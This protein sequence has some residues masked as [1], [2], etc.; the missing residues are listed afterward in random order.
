MMIGAMKTRTLRDGRCRTT[1]VHRD[2]RTL[3]EC[4]EKVEAMTRVGP[5]H[6]GGESPNKKSGHLIER[7]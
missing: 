2:S 3:S 6:D 4:Y 7:V 5:D 1:S